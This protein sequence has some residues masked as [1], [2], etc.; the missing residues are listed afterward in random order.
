MNYS[1]PEVTVLGKAG[2]V[3]ETIDPKPDVQSDS[4]GDNRNASAAYDLDE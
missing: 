2:R 1:K 3:I 4:L